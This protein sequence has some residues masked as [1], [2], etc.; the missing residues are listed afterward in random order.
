MKLNI[1]YQGYVQ[2][3]LKDYSRFCFNKIIDLKKSYL[4]E[5]YKIRKKKLK[6]IDFFKS[7]G[8]QKVLKVQCIQRK[9]DCLCYTM[10][11]QILF[12]LTIKL[13][14]HL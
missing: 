2:I 12:V 11:H 8:V 10:K 14:G 13:L 5:I 6:S 1:F 7:I 3:T 9:V 4:C